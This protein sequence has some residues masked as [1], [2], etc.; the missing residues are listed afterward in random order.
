[1]RQ[2]AGRRP[3]KQPEREQRR[4]SDESEK[5]EGIWT[6]QETEGRSGTE[7]READA[8]SESAA[9]AS[10]KGSIGEDVN[11][12]LPPK[13]RPPIWPQPGP[14]QPC[15]GREDFLSSGAFCF[16]GCSRR[17]GGSRSCGAQNLRNLSH[18][19]RVAIRER[20][21]RAKAPRLRGLTAGLKPRPSGLT[22]YEMGSNEKERR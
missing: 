5:S 15:P 2:A 20:G 8:E 19:D 9:A 14:A 12:S 16:V 18:K 4:D 1:M 11:E 3:G 7:E 10:F 21:F 13:P 17:V 22:T 6:Q